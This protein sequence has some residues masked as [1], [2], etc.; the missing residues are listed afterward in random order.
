MRYASHHATEQ[1]AHPWRLETAKTQRVHAGDRPGTHG[2]NIPDNPADTGRRALKRLDRAGVIV[3]LELERHTEPISHVDHAGVFLAGSDDDLGRLGWEGLEQ[4]PS[5]F[6]GAVLAPHH[7]KNTQLSKVGFSAEHL[8]NAFVLLRGDAVFLNDF[9]GD[10]GVGHQVSCRARGAES[11]GE[12]E[13][14]SG[15][16]A[17][18]PVTGRGKIV[19]RKTGCKSAFKYNAYFVAAMP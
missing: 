9:R 5:V 15:R 6:V 1:L 17:S 14:S 4:Q 18:V 11:G 7:G 2:E 10:L 8:E 19:S 13:S 12:T 16:L 3:R